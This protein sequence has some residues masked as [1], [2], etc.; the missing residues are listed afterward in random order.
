MFECELVLYVGGGCFI[1]WLVNVVIG[2]VVML[3]SFEYKLVSV[4]LSM[5]LWVIDGKSMVVGLMD[6]LFSQIGGVI[7]M[8][9]FLVLVVLLEGDQV[10]LSQGGELLQVGQCWKVVYL[11]EEFKDL[12]IGNL[13]GCKEMLVGII[14]I[15]CVVVQIF[16]G[17]VEEDGKLGDKFFVV[18]VIELCG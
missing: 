4:D 18:G 15:D 6:V 2:Q 16:Y 17:M 12:Q 1:L 5:M 10:V 7:V 8:E 13:L 14:C 11:G 3:Q 9:I